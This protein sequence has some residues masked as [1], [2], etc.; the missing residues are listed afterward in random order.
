L[1]IDVDDDRAAA[2]ELPVDSQ[3]ACQRALAA[4]ALHGGDRD[5]RVR[6]VAVSCLKLLRD[7]SIETHG[8]GIM[9]ECPH[10]KTAVR[11]DSNSPAPLQRVARE[12]NDFVVEFLIAE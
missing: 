7:E 4:A 5:D 9:Q 12:R 3:A 10:F 1:R 6:H 2:F 8:I 11:G